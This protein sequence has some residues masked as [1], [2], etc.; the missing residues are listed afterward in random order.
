M[1][2]VFVKIEFLLTEKLE[3]TKIFLMRHISLLL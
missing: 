2:N 1:L 3:E